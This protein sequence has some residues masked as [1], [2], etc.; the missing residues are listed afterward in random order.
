MILWTRV[1]LVSFFAAAALAATGLAWHASSQTCPVAPL[2]ERQALPAPQAAAPA[3]EPT[4]QAIA[5]GDDGAFDPPG[6]PPYAFSAGGAGTAITGDLD[7]AWLPRGYIRPLTP[8]QTS[9]LADFVNG[10]L[11]DDQAPSIEYRRGVVRVHSDQDR[12]DEPPYPLSAAASGQ[13]FC[14]EPAIWMRDTIR[15]RLHYATPGEITCSHNV[16]S[17]GGSE[18]AP[19]GYLFFHPATYMDEK[20]WVLDAW[21]EVYSAA[22]S[23]DVVEQNDA[24]VLRLMKRAATTSCPGEPPGMY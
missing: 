21:V 19:T 4:P 9:E 13:R 5:A 14:G 2:A 6:E 3:D 23:A 24:D 17:Y 7:L 10:W 1:S 18:Y 20:T 11:D 8:D 15:E 22:L 16:C 12:G